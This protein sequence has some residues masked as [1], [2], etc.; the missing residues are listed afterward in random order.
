MKVENPKYM[1]FSVAAPPRKG[2]SSKGREKTNPA[3]G[4][5]RREGNEHVKHSDPGLALKSLKKAF[6]E[7]F[8]KKWLQETLYAFFDFSSL[9]LAF[10]CYHFPIFYISNEAFSN[11]V[12]TMIKDTFVDIFLSLNRYNQDVLRKKSFL[13]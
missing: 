8:G 4:D 5:L 2:F 13:I 11:F 10:F 1:A 7:L 6:F 3:C 9:N 12:N